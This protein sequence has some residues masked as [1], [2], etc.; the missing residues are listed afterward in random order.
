M[1]SPS[2]KEFLRLSKKGNV[3]PVYK[4]INADLDTPVSAFL[5]VRKN[6]YSFLFES[7][8]G[9]AK[10]ARFSFLGTDPSLI[11]K[12]KAK[13]IEISYPHKK[14][15]RRFVTKTTPLDE[16]KKIRK[17][18]LFSILRASNPN[19]EDKA[20]FSPLKMVGGV[21]GRL[22]LKIPRINEDIPA[23]AKVFLK[24]PSLTP[25]DESQ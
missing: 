21:F 3:I 12:S 10:I 19:K 20:T 16:I 25:S 5:K 24:S 6:D 15:N 11:F 7:V 8:E 13:N 4:E 2:F 22:K 9:Q 23:I 18:L 17:F 14:L 1:Y